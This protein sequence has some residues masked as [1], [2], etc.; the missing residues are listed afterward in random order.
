MKEV[1]KFKN[2]LKVNKNGIRHKLLNLQTGRIM[3]KQPEYTSEFV[4]I[5]NDL[6][7]FL[8]HK[9]VKNL[10]L[11]KKSFTSLSIVAICYLGSHGCFPYRHDVCCHRLCCHGDGCHSC[12]SDG[13]SCPGRGCVAD[14]GRNPAHLRS[15]DFCHRCSSETRD[16][17]RGCY[18]VASSH[19][20]QNFH[21]KAA[22]SAEAWRSRHST[23]QAAACGPATSCCSPMVDGKNR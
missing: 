9:F 4:N 8:V 7:F 12:R 17:D 2:A 21:L 14:G 22:A 5:I 10:S 19:L 13:D 6:F 3:Y 16:A 23:G 20:C 11:Y 15:A 18:R 1:Y